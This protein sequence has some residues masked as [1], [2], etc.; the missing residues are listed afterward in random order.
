M[1]TAGEFRE[2]TAF[3]SM[4]RSMAKER[5][6]QQRITGRRQLS[7]G[8]LDELEHFLNVTLQRTRA[9]GQTLMVA[10]FHCGEGEPLARWW[11]VSQ[12][13]IFADGE[14]LYGIDSETAALNA[15]KNRL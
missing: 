5:R 10:F 11:C 7:N 4:T 8:Q 2:P 6:A 15:V 3:V 1:T 14:R 9:N 13:L 12:E